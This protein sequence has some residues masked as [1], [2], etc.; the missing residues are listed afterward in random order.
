MPQPPCIAVVILKGLKPGNDNDLTNLLKY[1]IHLG[2]GA[3]G[4]VL[5]SL[6]ALPSFRITL[7]RLRELYGD[8][9]QVDHVQ[10]KYPVSC[11]ISL[12]P[13]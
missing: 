4:I 11:T 10:G 6:L 5:V 7:N 1:N 9:T 13:I 12:P 2:R 3:C 8:Q